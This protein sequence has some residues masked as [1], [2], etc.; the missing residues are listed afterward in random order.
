MST[1]NDFDYSLIRVGIDLGTTNSEAATSLNV[2]NRVEIVKNLEGDDYT[3]SIFAIDRGGNYLIGKRAKAKTASL[4]K[5]DIENSKREIKRLMGL[6]EK[7]FFSRANKE[8]TPE[9]ISAEILKSLRSDIL[10]KKNGVNIFSAVITVPANFETP[11]KE[12]TLRA[13]KLAGFDYVE[14]LQEPVAAA[15]AYGCDQDNAD[16]NYLVFDFGG[17]TFDAAIISS[18]DKVLNIINH[19]GDNF[20]GGKDIDKALY[21]NVI[22]PAIKKEFKVTTFTE[23]VVE[24][25]KFIA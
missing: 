23:E 8:F 5:E 6:D 10:A 20:L 2:G 3:P 11:Q 17:G 25:L 21:D 22:L 15:I 14:L 1:N 12:A 19:G 24:Y 4:H 16:S 9:E 13:G 18:R 7:Q